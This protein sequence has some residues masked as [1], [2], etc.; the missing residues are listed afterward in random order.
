MVIFEVSSVRRH[1]QQFMCPWLLC[2]L[3]DDGV[4]DGESAAHWGQAG[5]PAEDVQTRPAGRVCRGRTQTVA[6]AECRTLG[7]GRPSSGALVLGR[8][9]VVASSSAR[10]EEVE[11][12][13]SRRTRPPRANANGTRRR[14]QGTRRRATTLDRHAGRHRGQR[15]KACGANAAGSRQHAEACGA[16]AE[17]NRG[18]RASPRWPTCSRAPLSSVA[19]RPRRRPPW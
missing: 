4:T 1:P 5:A 11:H 9:G 7:G 13:A 6:A 14:V 19:R 16:K 18:V 3:G 17:G 2:E 12:D 10:R 8:D 15:A